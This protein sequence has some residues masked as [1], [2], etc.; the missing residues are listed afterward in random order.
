M[1]HHET[2]E[3]EETYLLAVLHS[4]VDVTFVQTHAVFEAQLHSR[5]QHR[6]RVKNHRNT[7]FCNGWT[8]AKTDELTR[9][10][11]AWQ[12]ASS[13]NVDERGEMP[14]R[15][16]KFFTHLSRPEPAG[17]AVLLQNT[18]KTLSSSKG[19]TLR[20]ITAAIIATS[21]DAAMPQCTQNYVDSSVLVWSF[22]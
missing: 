6:K 22:P 2:V 14:G 8:G 17:V 5:A 1:T 9:T 7:K 19:R 12:M 15:Y 10:S 13:A 16:L 11:C 21:R 4:E 18:P 3:E 20:R